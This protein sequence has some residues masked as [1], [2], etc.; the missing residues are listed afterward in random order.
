MIHK[1][2]DRP[3]PWTLFLKLALFLVPIYI[4]LVG[5]GIFALTSEQERRARATYAALECPF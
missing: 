5:L 2:I 4:V 1:D 3:K